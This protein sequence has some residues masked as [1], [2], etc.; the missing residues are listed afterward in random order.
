[1]FLMY[2]CIAKACSILLAFSVNVTQI[3]VSRVLGKIGQKQRFSTENMGNLSQKIALSGDPKKAIF[4]DIISVT[5]S[6]FYDYFS[7]VRMPRLNF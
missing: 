6:Q 4:S 5:M 1:M 7:I 2:R 3:G